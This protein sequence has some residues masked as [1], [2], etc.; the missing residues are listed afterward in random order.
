M[1]FCENC[2]AQLADE[3]V[4]CFNCGSRQAEVQ[5]QQPLQQQVPVQGTVPV[6]QP[7]YAQ[8]TNSMQQP[9]KNKLNKKI[10][11][12]V[13]IVIVAVIAIFAIS[14]QIKKRVNLNQYISVEYSGYNT[15]GRARYKIDKEGLA[16]AILKAQGK[17][18]SQI[19]TDS[20]ASD[21][22]YSTVRECLEISLDKSDNLSNGD[23]VKLKIKCN[24]YAN[25]LLGIKLIYKDKDYKVENLDEAR[26][27][28]VFDDISVSFSGTSPNAKA[29]IE[30]NSSDSYLSGLNFKLS[31]SSG[32]KTGDKITVTVSYNE[33]DALSNG[34]ILTETSK[35][36]T[37]D[38]LDAYI[39]K[40]DELSSGQQEE[41][42]KA[43]KDK[44]EA[45]C[46]K[47]NIS[48]ANLNYAGAYTLVSKSYNYYGNS[49]QVY[50]IYSVD[51]TAK[52][53]YSG[54]DTVTQSVYMAVNIN[55][56]LLKSNGSFSYNSSMSLSGRTV[57]GNTS[58]SCYANGEE[59]Y[60]SLITKQKDTY[61]Y[62][63]S[64]GI[65]QFGE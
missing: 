34:Y 33:E 42:K 25:S 4:F 26:K 12:P 6:Q 38:K 24:D 3:D 28:N 61:T 9:V 43:A 54:T 11:I 27:V 48:P 1:K 62:S 30:N 36:Y 18:N 53:G 13:A 37:C 44:I 35:E 7:V 55:N 50:V 23:T 45:Y 20:S 63:V 65:K 32:I 59:L 60:R 64:G 8:G 49:N 22:V 52:K 10:I 14:T 2:G 17:K 21:T 47:S 41:L 46:A 39:S 31:K 58:V 19:L 29:T 56:V 57:I 15:V 40:V 16:K 5:Q 51:I